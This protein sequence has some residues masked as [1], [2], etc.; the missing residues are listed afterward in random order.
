MLGATAAKY[1]SSDAIKYAGAIGGAAIGG[2]GIGLG[3]AGQGVYFGRAAAKYAKA[4]GIDLSEASTMFGSY[5]AGIFLG[6]EVTLKVGSSVIQLLGGMPE[7][8]IAYCALALGSTFAMMFV[9]DMPDDDATLR[10]GVSML[11]VMGS[12][13]V[14]VFAFLARERKVQLLAFIQFAFGFYM[15]FL[16]FYINAQVVPPVFQSEYIG[17]FAAL[18][19]VPWLSFFNKTIERMF[20]VYSKAAVLTLMVISFCTLAAPFLVD[21]DHEFTKPQVIGLYLAAGVARSSYEYANRSVFV[22][23]FPNDKEVAMPCILLLSSL[24]TVIGFITFQHLRAAIQALIV[25]CV[26]VLA[27]LL[28]RGAHEIWVNENSISRPELG[29]RYLEKYLRI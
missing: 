26:S 23:F 14:S 25:C 17:L 8:F 19:A 1:A 11:Q 9:G 12:N 22:D 21:D 16:N 3:W 5:F 10:P 6:F 29:E 4:E 18:G 27:L 20:G 7:F 28:Y 24:T 13:A 15:V 2:L